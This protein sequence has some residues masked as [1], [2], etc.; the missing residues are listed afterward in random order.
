MV[1]SQT[2]NLKVFDLQLGTEAIMAPVEFD[3]T[4]I[5][6]HTTFYL[7]KYNAQTAWLPETP[8]TKNTF[9]EATFTYKVPVHEKFEVTDYPIRTSLK[10]FSVIDGVERGGCSGSMVSSR[11]VLTAAHCVSRYRVD[12]LFVDSILAVPIYDNGEDHPDFTSS[13]VEK[14]Y[15]FEDWRFPEDMAL[16]ELAEPIGFVTGWLSIGFNQDYES[17]REGIYYKFSYPSSSFPSLD[18]NEYNGDTLYYSYGIVDRVDKH[19]MGIN[20]TTGIPGESGS[21][22]IRIENEQTYTTYGALSFGSLVHAHITN[23]KYYALKEVLKNHLTVIEHPVQNGNEVFIYPNPVQDRFYLG[24]LKSIESIDLQVFNGA[25]E[26]LVN[27]QGRGAQNAIDIST[28]KSGIYFLRLTTKRGT[29]SLRFV[30]K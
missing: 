26:E 29:Q 22:L 11:H 10:L 4:I 1:Y 12:S 2:K 6:E 7:G 16:L 13:Y 27:V 9:P 3:S 5:E 8:P 20:N 24:N 18:T 19:Y 30:K 15:L 17:L 21:S 14:V 28:L 25:G 23:W